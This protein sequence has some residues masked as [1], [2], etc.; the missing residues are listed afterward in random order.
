MTTEIF[1][2][3]QF[4]AAL[5]KNRITQKP[6][7]DYKGF[8]KGEHVYRLPVKDGIEIIIR[9]SID[10]S[11]WCAD[12]GEDSIKVI[13]WSTRHDRSLGK[14]GRNWITREPGWQQRLIKLLR[15][16]YLRGRM[17][18]KCNVCGDHAIVFTAKTPK[19]RGRQFYKCLGCQSW[20]GWLPEKQPKLL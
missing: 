1:S 5:P 14:D 17:T 4:E 2:K 6:L 8:V 19:N 16:Q 12:T 13:L 7:C 20:L 11:G 9:S 15:Q 3:S 10:G 18:A